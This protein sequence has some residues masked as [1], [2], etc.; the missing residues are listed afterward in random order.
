MRQ[1]L[2]HLLDPAEQAAI[3]RLSISACIGVAWTSQGGKGQESPTRCSPLSETCSE[4]CS[5]KRNSV[6][7]TISFSFNGIEVCSRSSL[8]SDFSGAY[9]SFE[10]A[11]VHRRLC[12]I[13]GLPEPPGVV[14][15]SKILLKKGLRA[16]KETSTML[17]KCSTIVQ[18][19]GF[20]SA[21][22]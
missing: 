6:V 16:G 5:L 17:D 13:D 19:A 14:A 20:Q 8:L 7:R 10:K 12:L 11:G 1:I 21:H 3:P 18:T 15:A 22:V 9:V 4:V 2:S